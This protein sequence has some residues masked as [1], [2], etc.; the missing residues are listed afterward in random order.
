MTFSV[1]QLLGGLSYATTLFL[2]AAGL[3][4]IFGVTRI[5]NFAHGSFFMLG[6][7]F[8]AHWVTHW[9]PAWGESAPL[10]LLAILLGAACA[11]LAGAVAEFLL[12][13]R[14]TGAPELYQLVATFGLTLAMH[15]AMQWGFGP[16]E[17]FAPRFPGLKGSVQIGDEF[18]PVYQL[19]MIALGPL[20]WLG[21]HLL[22]RRSLFGQRLR[23]ATQDRSMLQALGVNPRPLMLGAVVLGCALAGLAGALQLPREPAHLQ[24][25]MNVIVETFV[26]VVMGG[27][28]S[29]GGAFVAALLIGLVH[30]FGISVFPQATLVIVFLTMAV[31]L[32]FRPQG[33]NGKAISSQEG[34][35]REPAQKFRGLGMGL[36]G[37][38]LVAAAFVVL[39]YVAWAGGPYW[40]ALAADALIL[41]IFGVS[42]QSMMALGGLVSFG[43]AAFFALGAYG[44][45]LSH[46]LWGASLPL[47]L[48]T[49]CATALAVAAV[50]GAAVVRSSGV[51]LAML[52]LALAQVVW[53][54]ATQWVDLTGGD[55]GLIGLTLVS[56]EVRPLFY[57]L[58]VGLVLVAVFALRFLGRSVLGA[59]LQALRDAPMRASASGLAV[60]WL[61]YR[62]FVESAV[63]AGLAGG[64]FAAHKGAVFPSLAA[65]STSVDA[66]L[67]VLLGGVHQLW[68]AVVGSIVLSYAGAELGREV[69]YWRGLLGVFIMLIMVASPSGLMGLVGRLTDLL[70]QPRR[71]GGER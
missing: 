5:V 13:R 54:G 23:A 52:S 29:I 33:L 7:L 56:D 65:V 36:A 62:I 66:L 9:F 25:D 20:V 27:L 38:S 64:L 55:N 41:M 19:A 34:G 22:L 18:F 68:G 37:S 32:V 67:V 15:D 50:F 49:G 24:M 61:K 43:H 1:V 59:A 63:L 53:A 57:A 28:G 26:V 4:L 47:A 16:D 44:A 8:T 21:L 10:Y 48:A 45:A 31:V 35:V 11:A 12:L 69:T 51:Y 3:T 2:M 70:K 42:L 14:M 39:A 46:S 60:G 71:G 30:A 17:V 58:L 40:Q 6:A